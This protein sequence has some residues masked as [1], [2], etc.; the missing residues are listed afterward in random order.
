MD[1]RTQRELD[2]LLSALLDGE[3][4]PRQ[5]ERLGELLGQSV[6][7]RDRYLSYFELQAE[8]ALGNSP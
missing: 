6:E 3:F 4:G 8:L 1:P 7:A 2:D 5:E